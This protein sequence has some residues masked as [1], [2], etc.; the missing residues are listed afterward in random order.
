MADLR[1]QK[2]EA[3]TAAASGNWRKAATCYANLERSEP[4]E[5]GWPLKLGES[6]RKM[7]HD[8]EAIKAYGRSA[9]GYAKNDLLLKAIA[10]CKII[11]GI[12]ATH[13]HT[14]ELL[15]SLYAAQG[16]PASPLP[17]SP[18]RPATLPPATRTAAMAPASARIPTAVPPTAIAGATTA[19]PSS[20]TPVAQPRT[21]VRVAAPAPSISPAA[22]APPLP[23]LRLAALIPGSRQSA[24]IPSVGSSTAMRIPI[25][26]FFTGPTTASGNPH[27]GA[28]RA[29]MARFVLPKTPFFSVLT[30]EL[31]RMAVER[32]RLIQ[33]AAGEVLFSKGD[34][35]DALF[36]VAWGEIAILVPRKWRDSPRGI[37]SA[38][39]L[40]SP[41][42]RAAPRPAPPWT[43]RCWLSTDPCSMI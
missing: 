13:T 42:E 35:G 40:C 38:R 7:G 21:E 5:P 3:L 2:Q 32:V 36:V 34:P 33:L 17:G 9:A 41:I 6:L 4:A 11:L 22:P 15:A 16:V 31:F 27:K 37:S 30:P 29:T 20:M 12:D 10:V 25:D 19:P 26:D 28:G 14:Q 23:Q 39:S 24:Q 8:G 43:A 18:S 1:K